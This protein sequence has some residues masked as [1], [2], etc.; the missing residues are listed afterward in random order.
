MK[1]RYLI[2]LIIAI[3]LVLCIGAGF[4]FAY[5]FTDVFKSNKDLFLK[6]ISQ[7]TEIMDFVNDNDVKAYSDKQ[8]QTSYTSEGTIK[9]NVTFP[10]SSQAQIANALQNCNISFNNKVDNANKYFN[11]TV[12]ANYSDNQSIEFNLYRNN[13]VF[14][15]KINDVLYKY[16]GFENN[17][18][19]E[20]AQKM[21]LPTEVISAISNKIE[22]SKIENSLNVFSDEDISALKNKYLKIITDNLT[23]DM[24]SKETSSDEIIYSITL[25]E[26][27][28]KTIIVALLNNLKDD[29]II[30]N[31]LKASFINNYNLTEETVNPYV[32][33]FKQKIQDLI[34]SINSSTSTGTTGSGN[35]ADALE[36]TLG[37][38]NTVQE[39]SQSNT[40][41]NLTIK[42]H[43]QQ[44]QLVKTD[45]ILGDV[46][47]LVLSKSDDGVKVQIFQNN[48]EIISSYMQ[49]IKSPT[50][51]KYELVFSLNNNQ[52][53]DLTVGYAGLDT[54]SVNEN[55]ELSFDIDLGNS[56]ITDAKT[57]I[58]TNYKATKTFDSIQK[59]E[60]QNSDILF[61]NTA[62]SI[63]NIET[64]YKNIETKFVG[65][66]QTKL[67]ALGLTNEQNPF[68][69][70]IPSVIPV[71]ANYVLLNPDKAPYFSIPAILTGTSVVILTGENSILRKAS[72]ASND[73]AISNVK[74][75]VL[76]T[77]N[78]ALQ[79]YYS[80]KYSKNL[81]TDQTPFS[82]VE[83]A[84]KKFKSKDVNIEY[85]YSN[86][87]ITLK[88]KKDSKTVTG[89][90][91]DNGEIK[92]N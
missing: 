10:D 1:K 39:P 71:C 27:Q 44:R 89:T 43:S 55:S 67:Q 13:D 54:N 21:N 9:T 77:A 92:W 40:E 42:V 11:G 22:F 57:K 4:A 51:I 37:S 48:N 78:E 90:L 88:N 46:G 61:L 85:T 81:N 41:S 6:Y 20:F 34:D 70:Y 15:G 80:A 72:N 73:L 69:Y 59:E 17:N 60:I 29:E 32:D 58:V 35:F 66:N 62:P 24:F 87:I 5:F 49:K 2:M 84:L 18:L 3:V 53:F 16:V 76:V 7:N 74:E 23:D 91:S 52:I 79:N 12:K 86:K 14:A 33:Q 56:T 64:L 63:G 38:E 19:K 82:A 83:T 75:D 26:T 25:N 68:G 47:S 36:Q 31:K 8:K 50:E 30:I 45:F 65:L 28:S